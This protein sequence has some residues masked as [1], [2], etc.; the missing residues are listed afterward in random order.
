MEDESEWLFIG[1]TAISSVILLG[2]MV[3]L[4]RE[5]LIIS[6]GFE[7]STYSV[8]YLCYVNQEWYFIY[9]ISA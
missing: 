1:L 5:V 6:V 2:V 4:F 9:H 8:L 3:V 7:Y